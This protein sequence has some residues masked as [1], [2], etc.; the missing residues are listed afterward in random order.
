MKKGRIKGQ[1]VL[2]VFENADDPKREIVNVT[3]IPIDDLLPDRYKSLAILREGL[4]AMIKDIEMK[5][6]R[7]GEVFREIFTML[8]ED[9]IDTDFN[10]LEADVVTPKLRIG[11]N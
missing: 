7:P 3:P 10:I 1:L 2:T 6:S 8:K 11:E 5:E 9:Y 4:V